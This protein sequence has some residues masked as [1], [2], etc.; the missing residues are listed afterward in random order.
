MNGWSVGEATPTE[1]EALLRRERELFG[2]DSALRGDWLFDR[3]PAGRAL[4]LVAR[5]PDRNVVGT[6]SLLPWM[7]LADG[8]EVR[9]GQY[10]R[11]WTGPTHRKLGVSVAIGRELNRR[12]VEIGYPMIFLFPSVRSIPGHRTVGNRLVVTLERRQILGSARFFSTRAP[13]FLDRG[14]RLVRR[15]RGRRARGGDAWAVDPDAAATAAGLWNPDALG[16]GVHGLRDA[17]FLAWRYSP[18]SGREYVGWRTPAGGPARF[19]AFVHRAGRRARILEVMG[20]GDPGETAAAVAVLAE[21][22]IGQGAYLVEWCPPRHGPGPEAADRA[23]FFRRRSG[24]PLGL[25]FNRG[26]EESGA[27]GDPSRYHLTEGDS[28]YA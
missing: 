5:G 7:V 20:S 14:V 21:Q 10:A 11:S 6:R 4:V 13:G 22:L 27:L 12:S 9:V 3:N 25:W 28:D 8:K 24:V 2:A 15:A 26:P 16:G 18:E 19:S 1:R 17:A 23:G